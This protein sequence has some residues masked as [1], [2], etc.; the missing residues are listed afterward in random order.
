MVARGRAARPGQSGHW[1]LR[2]MSDLVDLRSSNGTLLGEVDEAPERYADYFA[3]G[4][5]MLLDFWVNNLFFLALA[6]KDARPL[7]EAL[8]SQSPPPPHGRYVQWLRNHDEL[9]LERLTPDERAEVFATFAPEPGMRAYERGIRRRLAPMFGGDRRLLALA[10][11]LLLS[12]PGTPILRYGDEIGM[13][14]DL[15]LPER[16][17]VRTPMQW[18]AGDTGG[19][20]EAPL[21]RFVV[22]PVPDEAYG[23]KAVNVEDQ[24]LD[25]GSLL[26][27]VSRLVRTRIALHEIGSG[28]CEV[29]DVGP[30]GVFAACHEGSGPPVVTLVN[31]GEREATVDLAQ[32]GLSGLV[33]VL[34]DRNYPHPGDGSV[35]LDGYGYRWLRA[36]RRH[37]R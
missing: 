25:Q 1:L 6:R 28:T 10:H 24:S 26:V 13:G 12:L 17:S 3:H 20:S 11:A 18:T 37:G 16:Q 22:R 31:L 14:D 8:R 15:D 34:S 29:L 4:M 27:E 21:D 19:F 9:D 35:S 5:T 33:D 32:H 30:D 36:R 7:R 2:E 23:P